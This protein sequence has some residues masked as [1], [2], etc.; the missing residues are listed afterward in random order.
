MFCRE[1]AENDARSEDPS[2]L[3]MNKI[4]KKIRSGHRLTIRVI[5]ESVVIISVK[6]QRKNANFGKS[7]M[8][9]LLGQH[10]GPHCIVCQDV[11]RQG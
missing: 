4:I 5:G 8:G 9:S 7:V 11:S 1:K 10:T 6:N 2:T 3:K